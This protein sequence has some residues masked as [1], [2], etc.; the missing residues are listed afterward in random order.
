MKLFIQKMSTIQ[1]HAVFL[2]VKYRVI[3]FAKKMIVL[4]Q[5]IR[6]RLQGILIKLT[7]KQRIRLYIGVGFFVIIVMILIAGYFMTK[8]T[9]TQ[10]DAI[11][12]ETHPIQLNKQVIQDDLNNYDG[13]PHH[14]LTV[15]SDDDSALKSEFDVLKSA[16]FQQFNDLHIQLQAMQAS[17]ATLPSQQDMQQLQQTVAQ[18]NPDLLGKINHL[19]QSMQLIVNQ[20]AKQSWVAP[21]LVEKYFRLAAI[22]GF[23]DGMRAIIDVDG[24]QT[25]LSINESCPACRSWRLK[26]LDFTNQSAVFSKQVSKQTLYVKLQTN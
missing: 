1:H 11:H 13:K 17:L 22:Q 15:N 16:A 12:F 23:S 26:T 14:K 5:I 20:T 10:H 2:K 19:Q 6:S 25:V 7:R 9:S 24:N 21:G 4:Y 8:A 3:A 18:P